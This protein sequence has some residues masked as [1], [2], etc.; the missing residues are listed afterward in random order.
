MDIKF[1]SIMAVGFDLDRTMYKDSS[2]M[3][4]KIV[5][6]IALKVLEIKP[7]LD[8]IKRVREIYDEEARILGSWPKVLLRLGISDPMKIMHSCIESA[9]ILDLI[10]RDEKLVKIMEK[11]HQKYFL[12]LITGSSKNF[13]IAVLERIGINPKLFKFTLFGDNP[14]GIR[15]YDDGAFKHFLAQSPFAPDEHVYIGDNPKTDVHIPRFLGMKAIAVGKHVE[16]ADYSVEHIHEIE[17][18]LL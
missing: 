3:N 10:K 14:Q 6:K 18:L 1:A 16:G 17:S 5:D 13:A 11:L 8:S 12:F 7:E 9:D 4:S 2:E 15:K